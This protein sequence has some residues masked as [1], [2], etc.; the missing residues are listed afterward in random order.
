MTVMSSLFL[1]L[2]EGNVI[3]RSYFLIKERLL[4]IYYYTHPDPIRCYPP[5]MDLAYLTKCSRLFKQAP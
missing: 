3:H 4:T 2:L 5:D 1:S